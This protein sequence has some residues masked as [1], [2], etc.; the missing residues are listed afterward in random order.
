MCVDDIIGNR[1]PFLIQEFDDAL[2]PESS[3]ALM[4]AD[5]THFQHNVS[6]D[7]PLL[8]YME[9]FRKKQLTRTDN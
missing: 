8:D 2:G 9:R 4:A 5:C 6:A 3:F 7:V 1:S